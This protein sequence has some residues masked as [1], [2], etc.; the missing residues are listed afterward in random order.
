M[1]YRNPNYCSYTHTLPYRYA[2]Y[3]PYT[4]T[5]LVPNYCS[6]THTL[7]VPILLLLHTYLVGT[8]ATVPAHIPF[9]YPNYCSCTHALQEPKLLLLHTYLTLQV[10]KL[11]SLY[12]Y[13]TGTQTTA[14]THT[15][16]H[17][18]SSSTETNQIWISFLFCVKWVLNL[19]LPL[20]NEVW[21]K[22]IFSQASVCPQGVSL[23]GGFLS[24]G[25]LCLGGLCLGGLC[26]GVFVWGVS[27]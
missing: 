21:G 6:C 16:A 27:V 25:G 5:P 12:T 22:V 20:A 24:G 17:T 15:T 14:P 8:Q 2:N 18:D 1:P 9:W 4:H 11:L 10:C 19:F 7:Q 13:P 3:C 26:L 23:S